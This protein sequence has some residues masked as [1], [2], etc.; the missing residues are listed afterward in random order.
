M[1]LWINIEISV[2]CL[3]NERIMHPHFTKYIEYNGFNLREGIPCVASYYERI[4]SLPRA[5]SCRVDV[6]FYLKAPRS[7]RVD[8]DIEPSRIYTP[9]YNPPALRKH[10]L[11]KLL[12]DRRVPLPWHGQDTLIL[13][14]ARPNNTTLRDN[15]FFARSRFRPRSCTTI[16]SVSRTT[17]SREWHSIRTTTTTTTRDTCPSDRITS[18]ELHAMKLMRPDHNTV[19]KESILLIP[20][21]WVGWIGS[22]W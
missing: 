12:S 3:R 19:G 13:R 22:R 17:Q 16:I 20:R 7:R 14:V 8:I 4:R 2:F 10:N 6:L 1:Y 21:I 9:G 18:G 5:A 15:Y 11:H